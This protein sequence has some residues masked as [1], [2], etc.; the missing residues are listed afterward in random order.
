METKDIIILVVAFA[1][2]GFSLYRRYVKQK[3]MG[4][5]GR[6]SGGIGP[7]R[8]LKDQPDDYEPY[9]GRAGSDQL[10]SSS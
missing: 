8:S 9:A 3:S 1:L 2:A 4:G 6:S 10:P 7:K 5:K